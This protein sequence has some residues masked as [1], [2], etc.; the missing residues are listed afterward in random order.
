MFTGIQEQGF[1]D[2]KNDDRLDLGQA[3]FITET[4]QK[5]WESSCK[6]VFSILLTNKVHSQELAEESQSQG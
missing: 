2:P 4:S 5:A 1:L 6:V 3:P